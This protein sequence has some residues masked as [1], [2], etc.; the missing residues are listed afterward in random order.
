MNA[1]LR[2]ADV[3]RL[4][5]M[6]D[7][8]LNRMNP[9]ANPLTEKGREYQGDSFMELLREI[10]QSRAGKTALSLSKLELIRLAYQSTS[11]FPNLLANVANKRL[12]QAYEES[13]PTYKTW[14]RRGANAPDFKEINVVQMSSMP[15]LLRTNEHGEF[16][17]S[18]L[19]DGKEVY[20]LLTFGRILPFTRQAMINDD[21][22]GFDRVISGFARSA[23]RLENRTVYSELTANAALS[24]G[25]A[26]F[27]ASHGN[28]TTGPGTAISVESLGVG[29]ALMRLQIGLQNEELNL[30]PRFLIVP[31]AQEQKA[32]QF[33]SA[34]YVPAQAADINEFRAGGRAS[35]EP[36]VEALLDANSTTAWYLAA[37]SSQIDT[38]EYCYLQ[39]EEGIQSEQR[40][41]F[42]IDGV[43]I[44][45]RL[46]FAAKAI[47][48][49]GL[50]RNDGA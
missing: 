22:R 6:T 14:A 47:D 5:G 23:A 30:S 43:E 35:L 50:Y 26:L 12:R 9:A 7:Y 4:A 38:V 15:D 29:R 40:F 49:R 24:D 28:L 34:Q 21:L 11:D 42:E 25:V 48:F 36:I 20:S 44:K 13:R 8:V 37:D 1:V 32:Y 19:T 3:T 16:K 46:D 27:H 2:D 31:S 17:Y 39:G 18:K 33:T 45:A 41:G 10:V